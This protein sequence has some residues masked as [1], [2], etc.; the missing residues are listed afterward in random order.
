MRTERVR[1]PLKSYSVPL[2]ALLVAWPPLLLPSVGEHPGVAPTVRTAV[3]A[4]SR[5]VDAATASAP[6]ASASLL[7]SL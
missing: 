4:A 6:D 1:T 5:T 7:R 3:T 2:T